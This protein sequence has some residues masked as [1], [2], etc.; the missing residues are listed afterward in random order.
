LASSRLVAGDEAYVQNFRQSPAIPVGLPNG[1][2]GKQLADEAQ[3]RRP[4]KDVSP[5]AQLVLD[6]VLILHIGHVEA[7]LWELVAF[8]RC[9]TSGILR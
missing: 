5:P 6:I 1:M 3:R 8:G 4:C 9:K 7:D 2:N